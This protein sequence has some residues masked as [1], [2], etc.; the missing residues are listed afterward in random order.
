M[1]AQQRESLR[2]QAILAVQQQVK[3][4]RKMKLRGRPKTEAPKKD[5]PLSQKTKDHKNKRP[6]QNTKAP[7][8]NKSPSTFPSISTK[9]STT[10]IQGSKISHL[11]VVNKNQSSDLADGKSAAIYNGTLHLQGIKS[12]KP[13]S[14]EAKTA[15]LT[16]VPAFKPIA[17]SPKISTTLSQP[18]KTPVTTPICEKGFVFAF[19]HCYE[20]CPEGQIMQPDGSCECGPMGGFK[21]DVL[22]CFHKRSARKGAIVKQ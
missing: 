13:T 3:R 5:K 12:E 15:N 11:G 2:N 8:T 7:T 20:E 17:V 21:K 14:S 10:V 1:V 6:S 4:I 18:K 19:G 16:N 9:N 22:F